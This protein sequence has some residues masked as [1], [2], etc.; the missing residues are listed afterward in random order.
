MNSD[1]SVFLREVARIDNPI[2]VAGQA[3]GHRARRLIDGQNPAFGDP[4]LLMAEDWM[5]RGAFPMLGNRPRFDP[6]LWLLLPAE[7]HP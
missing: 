7:D 5:P 4:F 6:N 1:G 3:R 2:A